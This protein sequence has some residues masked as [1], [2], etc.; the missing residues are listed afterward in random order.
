MLVH[1]S[2]LG[3][4]CNLVD[5]IQDRYLLFIDDLVPFLIDHANSPNSAVRSCVKDI[6]RKVE[7]L[8]GESIKAFNQ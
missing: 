7:N 6:I 4:M 3:L 5:Q 2:I 1:R 8:S